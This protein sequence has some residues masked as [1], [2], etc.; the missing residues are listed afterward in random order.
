MKFSSFVHEKLCRHCHSMLGSFHPGPLGITN[1]ENT[2]S[3]Y[4]M[5]TK[6]YCMP[7][8]TQFCMSNARLLMVR[9]ATT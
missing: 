6:Y 7:V 5:S 4:K 9:I 3:V 2:D 8:S 1:H